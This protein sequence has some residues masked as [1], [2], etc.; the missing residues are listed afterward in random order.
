VGIGAAISVQEGVPI[1]NQLLPGSPAELS[2]QLRPGDRVLALA[3]G[4][5]DFVSARDLPLS[6]VVQM[7]RGAPGTVLRLQVLPA[8]APPNSPPR[9]VS[10]LRDQIM[11]KR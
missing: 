6:D 3:Q 11:L 7:V 5:E 10:V 2:G 8:D 1:I 4:D 9:T